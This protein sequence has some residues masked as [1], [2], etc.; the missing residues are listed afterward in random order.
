MSG[1][2]VIAI[3]ATL[4]REGQCDNQNYSRELL[5]MGIIVHE[6]CLTYHKCNKT[7][8]SLYLVLILQSSTHAGRM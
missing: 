7:I 2:Q 5:M 6:A 4:E 1:L 3:T 8:S